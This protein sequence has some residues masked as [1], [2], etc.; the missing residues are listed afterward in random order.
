MTTLLSP[1]SFPDPPELELL[2]LEAGDRLDRAT[3]HARYLAMPKGVKAELVRGVVYM[4]SPAGLRHGQRHAFV[5]LWL[6]MYQ[7]STPGVEMADNATVF[8]NPESELQPDACLFI[9][10]ESGGQTGVEDDYLTG[11][12]ELVVEIASSS[13]SYDL[14]DKREEYERAGV[15]EYVVVLTRKP[16]VRWLAL[17]NGRYEELALGAD[18]LYRS[19]VFPGLWL[20]P[21]ALLRLDGKALRAALEQG[22]AAEDHAVFAARLADDASPEEER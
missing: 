7:T 16:G 3:F 8:P 12:P 21:A 2:P 10:S 22:L 9:R 4:P 13:A 15:Q 1:L 5:M 17:R 18:G 20:D 19:E 6:G 14:H 11:A